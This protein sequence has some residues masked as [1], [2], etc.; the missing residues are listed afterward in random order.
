[1]SEENKKDLNNTEPETTKPDEKPKKTKKSKTGESHLKAELEKQKDLFMRTAA[2]FDNFK[3]RTERE[4]LKTAEYAKATL[5]KKLLPV[6]DNANRAL[7]Q[8]P[9][10]P[11]YAKGIEMIVKQLCGVSVSKKLGG[12]V[13][14]GL[15]R[16][17]V[18]R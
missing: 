18:V 8:D 2:E 17:I 13:Q 1:M 11:D 5:I 7:G 9:T 10:N 16:Q 12:A 3:K 4:K 15:R 6:V 14:P